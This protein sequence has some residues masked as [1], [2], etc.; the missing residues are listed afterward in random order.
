MEKCGFWEKGCDCVKTRET[1][2]NHVNLKFIAA[3]IFLIV[4]YGVGPSSRNTV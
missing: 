3:G 1:F 4:L 2:V